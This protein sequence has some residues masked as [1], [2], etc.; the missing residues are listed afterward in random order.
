MAK[1]SRGK[2]MRHLSVVSFVVVLCLGAVGAHG[3]DFDAIQLA[4]TKVRSNVSVISGGGGNI[5]VLVGDDAVLLI[6]TQ[7]EQLADKI[8][9]A[10]AE[11]S[12]RPVRFIVNTH[13]HFDH[14]GCNTCFASDNPVIIGPAGTRELMGSDQE[15]PLLGLGSPAFPEEALPELSVADRLRLDCC[16][17]T[18]EMVHI[19]GAHSGH[20]LVVVLKDAN[21]IHAGDLYWSQG[22]PYV[23]S[24]HGGSLDGIIAA[25]NRMLAMADEETRIIPGHGAVTDR[26][27]LEAYRDMLVS[28]RDRIQRD[29]ESGLSI[30][31]I[32]AARPTAST[33]E[34]RTAGMPPELFVRLVHRDLTAH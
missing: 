2:I 12:D 30:E 31:E 8:R 32:L 18:V 15:F 23:G 33:D 3:Q 22:Y 24:P 4:V 27:G 25:S 6:D 29:I 21:V 28:V 9:A 1:P 10:V 14:T 7:M 17:E 19:E 34:A 5:G 11:V 26:A 20:D 16:G 13:W